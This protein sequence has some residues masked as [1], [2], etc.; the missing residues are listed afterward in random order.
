KSH[1]PTLDEMRIQSYASIIGG[2]KGLLYYSYFDLWFAD[3]K[4]I[5]DR[6]VFEQRWP[7]VVAMAKEINTLVPMLLEDQ[8]V[9]LDIA[10]YPRLYAAAWE[11]QNELSVLFANRYYSQITIT[12]TQP[13]G[14]AVEN[15]ASGDSQLSAQNGTLTLTAGAIGSGVFRL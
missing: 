4:R 12:F 14:W 9:T 11:Y 3:H 5:A 10:P 6:K 1:Q 13:D 15:V 8:K 7:N 2:A